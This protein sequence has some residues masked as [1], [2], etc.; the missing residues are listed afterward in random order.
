MEYIG[1]HM[2]PYIASAKPHRDLS[3]MCGDMAGHH[4]QVADHSPDAAPFHTPFLPGCASANCTL[5]DHPEYVVGDHGQFKDQCVSFKLPWREAFHIHVRLDL[6]VELLTFSMG[7]VKVDDI[8]VTKSKICPPGIDFDLRYQ[9]VL[10]IL[11]DRSLHDLVTGPEG[12][13]LLE[14][15]ACDIFPVTSYIDSLPFPGRSDITTVLFSHIIPA[16]LTFTAQVPFDDKVASFLNENCNI[17]NG[18]ITGIQ[19]DE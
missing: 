18:I 1:K 2:P 11:I 4:H 14:F 19:A 13:F 10:A 8:L 9:Q 12:K 16:V 7:M 6:T 15:P 3:C 17:I 5:T